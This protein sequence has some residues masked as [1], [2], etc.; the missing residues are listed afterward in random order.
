MDNKELLFQPRIV[1]DNSK[2]MSV[3]AQ[4]LKDDDKEQQ[5]AQNETVVKRINVVNDIATFNKE[6]TIVSGCYGLRYSRVNRTLRQLIDALAGSDVKEVQYYDRETGND[7][8]NFQMVIYFTTP[9]ALHRV[10]RAIPTKRPEIIVDPAEVESR[11]NNCGFMRAEGTKAFY[12]RIFGQFNMLK[13]KNCK[14]YNPKMLKFNTVYK[15]T[16]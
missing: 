14:G 16:L 13:S 11:L 5:T 15:N 12:E 8:H 1:N 7:W 6:D 10:R 4:W 3:I 9:S 2:I